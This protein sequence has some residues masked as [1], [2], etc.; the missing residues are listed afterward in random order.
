MIEKKLLFIKEIPDKLL[1]NIETRDVALWITGLPE[2]SVSQEKLISFLGLP[3]KFVISEISDSW[4]INTIENPSTSTEFFIRKRGFIQI[5]D[6][7]PSR[8]QLPPRCLPFYLLNGRQSSK[9][10]E[11]ENQLRRLTMLEAVRRSM[12]GE[13][14]VISG[15]HNPISASLKYLW[16]SGFRSYLSFVSDYKKTK[17]ILDDWVDEANSIASLSCLSTVEAIENMLERYMTSYPEDKL[18]IRVRDINGDF[19]KI[20][21]TDIDDPE[22]SILEHYSLIM[23]RDLS[24]LQ[25]HELP[26]NEFISFFQN[27]EC[28]WKPYAA[29]LPW[30]RD[31]VWTDRLK[32]YMKRLDAGGSEENFVAFISSEPGAGGTTVARALAWEFAKEGYPALLANQIP[33]VANPLAI[34]N[35]LLRAHRKIIEEVVVSV[36]DSSVSFPSSYETPWIIVYDRLHWEYREGELRR[37]CKK[38]QMMGRSVVLFIVTDSIIDPIFSNDANIFKHV[39]KL[40]HVL[41]MEEALNLGHHLNKF[42]RIYGKERQD[43]H[44]KKFH[45]EHTISQ[46]HGS[47]SFWITLS[48][49]I[50]G[51]Y[52]MSE[53]IQEWMYSYLKKNIQSKFLMQ[54]IFSIAS[55]SSERLPIPIGLLPTDKDELPISYQLDECRTSIPALG[56]MPI[57]ENGQNYWGLVHDI[58]GRFLINALFYDFPLRKDLGF[59]EAKDTEHLRFMILEK[60]STNRKLG[61][62]IFGTIAENFATFIFKIDPDHGRASFAPYWR[63]VLRALD[64]MPK[65]LRNNN[66]VF[67]HHSSIS[68]RRITKLNKELYD[69]KEEDKV[70]LLERAI[71]DI[72]YALEYIQ[73]EPGSET[74]LNLYNSLARAYLDLA[75]VEYTR[76]K[77][78]KR[79]TELRNLANAATRK[80]Y[81]ESPTNSYVI[82]TYV[83]NLLLNARNSSEI[84]IDNCIEALGILF[85]V[86]S[87][88]EGQYRLTALGGLSDEALSILFD[89]TAPE[90][91][92]KEPVSVVD[93]LVKTW[94]TLSKDI[95]YSSGFAL[96][97]I[98]EQ[99]RQ[100]AIEILS[101]PLGRGNMQVL[102]LSYQLM[103]VTYPSD[104][105]KQLEIVEQLEKSDYRVSPQQRLEYAILLYQN[106]RT[107]EGSKVFRFLRNLWRDSDHFVRVPKRLRWLW[108]EDG[109]TPKKVN[110]FVVS[111]YGFR[112]FAKV[113]EFSKQPVPFRQEEFSLGRMGPGVRKIICH[114]SFGHNGPFLRPVTAAPK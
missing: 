4:L 30:V 6:N 108:T 73:Y 38:L 105:K 40:D 17:E 83:K 60:I 68:R 49:W 10:T 95:E 52:D 56:L 47:S 28:S 109:I 103:C 9:P 94:I 53:S 24:P 11:F 62:N 39:G 89:Q 80:A 1:S 50:Q 41:N 71:K 54:V 92:D 96:S 90:Q 112:A 66:R 97:E 106:N 7:D 65:S 72:L 25:P 42:L 15:D 77:S 36:S 34:S 110:G 67:L 87:S 107:N 59:D 12:V 101:N 16:D 79:I 5:I 84:A 19:H 23:E 45:E 13:I 20:D 26:E 21:I 58:L 31:S 70:A 29:G 91:I 88:S 64:N 48:F 69:V 63:D 2:P 113:Q 93:V 99:N 51:Q 61:E 43:W 75:D 44:W 32:M 33:F 22:N 86:I 111:D 46:L 8:I 98:P 27:P 82:E 100:R 76:G 14:L 57:R 104:L 74:N 102:R 37:F 3:W 18:V 81:E 78:E 35:F 114:V 85:S 55:M